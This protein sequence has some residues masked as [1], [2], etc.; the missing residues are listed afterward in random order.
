MLDGAAAAIEPTERPGTSHAHAEI[1]SQPETWDATFSAVAE[2]W[3][4][5]VRTIPP[6]LWTDHPTH[7]LF[8]GCGTS[9]YLAQTAAHVFQE[10]TGLVSRAVPGSEIALSPA[11]TLPSGYPVVAFVFSR[12]GTSS[13]AVMAARYLSGLPGEVHTVGI[14]CTPGSELVGATKYAIEL[15]HAD[16]RSVV[17]TRSFTNMLLAITMIATT[18]GLRQDLA[19]QVLKLPDLLRVRLDEMAAF[20]QT[21]ADRLDLTRVIYLGL[22]PYYGLAEEATLKLKEMTQVDCEP[23]SSL[24]FRHGAMSMVAEDTLVVLLQGLRERAY[25]PDLEA[26]LKGYGATVA[27][28]GPYPSEHADISI[29]LPGGLDDVTRALL[30][31][32]ALQLLANQRAVA[33]GLDP[34]APRQLGKVVRL[35]AR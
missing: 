17:M 26:E 21:L 25:M 6:E 9:Y 7:V 31:L 27:T 13:E 16:E 8:V 19:Q 30:Y 14:T 28:V 12:S 32:P 10:V 34:D 20:A 5:I 11:S 2:Q 35:D 4:E 22:G 3:R 18:I 1:L 15:P 29:V 23:Y 24:E 33:L